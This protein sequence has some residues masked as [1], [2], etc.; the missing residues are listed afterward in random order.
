MVTNIAWG[1]IH[2]LYWCSYTITWYSLQKFY[3]LIDY[4]LTSSMGGESNQGNQ[5]YS[6]NQ[7]VIK[8]TKVIVVI[9]E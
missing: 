5:G 4:D 1:N 2:W 3:L 9:K 8:G 6:G 7:G